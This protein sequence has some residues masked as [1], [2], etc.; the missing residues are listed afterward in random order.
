MVSMN[1]TGPDQPPE[2]EPDYRF[3][4]ANE[5]T[6]LAW[7]RTSLALIAGG[8]AV[9]QLVPAFGVPGTRQLLGVILTSGGGLLAVAAVRRW[10]QV[11]TAMRRGVDLSPSRLPQL[12]ALG[13]LAIAVAILVVLIVQAS[14]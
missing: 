14:T 11:Q 2:Q 9:V 13:L 7:I 12:L 4:L 8:V 1:S 6:F 3:T 5:R 10:S